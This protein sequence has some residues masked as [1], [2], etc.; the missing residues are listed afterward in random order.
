M[1]EISVFASSVYWHRAIKTH[2]QLKRV[3]G[4]KSTTFCWGQLAYHL[5]RVE[6]RKASLTKPVYEDV[7]SPLG[8]SSE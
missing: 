2:I 4:P 6:T 7:Y 3:S 8:V 5:G 1:A